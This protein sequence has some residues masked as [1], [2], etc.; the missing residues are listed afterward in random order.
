M[1]EENRYNPAKSWTK[2]TAEQNNDP[3]EK[4]VFFTR[5]RQPGK[6]A[7]MVR[8]HKRDQLRYSIA[9]SAIREIIYHPE[10]GI[11]LLWQGGSVQIKGRN[12]EELEKHLS[13]GRVTEVREY[14]EDAKKFFDPEALFINQIL[15]ESDGLR[16][17]G[18]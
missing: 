3:L 10:A 6:R 16:N 11:I 8:F 13:E 14:S 15:C 4:S 17:M 9:T 7:D 18:L 5:L 12:L 1:D 2:T